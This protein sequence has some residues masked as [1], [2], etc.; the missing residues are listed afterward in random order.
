M[1]EISLHFNNISNVKIFFFFVQK[2]NLLFGEDG[3]TKLILVPFFYN[4][5]SFDFVDIFLDESDSGRPLAKES[6]K[7]QVFQK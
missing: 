6:R 2:E 4:V 3:D 7:I 1:S 5:M